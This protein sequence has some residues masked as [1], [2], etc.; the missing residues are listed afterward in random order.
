MKCGNPDC[1][2]EIAPGEKVYWVPILIDGYCSPT[3]LVMYVLDVKDG[4]LEDYLAQGGVDLDKAEREEQEKWQLKWCK[5][6][7]YATFIT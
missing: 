1:Q 7:S 3:C 4:T 6:C 2:K 5:G